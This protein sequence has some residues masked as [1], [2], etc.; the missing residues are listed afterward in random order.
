V[1]AKTLEYLEYDALRELVAGFAGS[2]LGK[3]ELRQLEPGIGRVALEATLATTAEALEYLSEATRSGGRRDNAVKLRFEGLPDPGV[4]AAKV[5]LEGAVLDASEIATFL[6]LLE[7]ATEIRSILQTHAARFPG[8]WGIAGQLADFHGVLRSL[9]GKILPDG[10][11]ADDASV[12]LTR[13]RRDMERQRKLITESLGRFLRAHRETG[14]LQEEFVTI[15]NDRFVIPV[16][17]GAKRKI[18]GVVHG[19]SGSGHTLFLEPLETIE[20]NN[21]LVRL[22]EEE[23]REIHRILR[24]MTALL[25]EHAA[26]VLAAVRILAELD[27]LF[28]K[29]RFAHDYDGV[30]PSFSP[31]AEPRLRLKAA[32]HPLLQFVLRRQKKPIVPVNLELDGARRT[33]LI[34][35]P[36]TGGKTVTLKTVG[37]LSLMAQSGLPVPAEEA[38]F[39]LCDEMLADIGD[40]QSIEQ[41]LSTF[42]AHVVRIGE[43]VEAV[44]PR[45]LVLLDELGRAT[46]PEEGGALGV[47]ILDEF[48][49]R[50]AFTLASTHLLA[51]KVYGASVE[52]VLNASMGFNETTLEPTYLLRIGTPGKSAGLEIATRIGLPPHLIK[53]A[54]RALSTHERDLARLLNQLEVRLT[55]AA[56]EAEA[57]RAQQ[58][59]LEVR[60]MALEGE[61]QKKDAARIREV[62]RRAAEASARFEAQAKETIERVLQGGGQ[63]KEAEHALR[64]VARTKREYREAVETLAQKPGAEAPK[65]LEVKEGARVRLRD[66]GQ[67]GRV[68]KILSGGIL[69]VELGLLKMHVASSEVTE[70]LPEAPPGVRL[71]QGVTFSARSSSDSLSREINVIG[72]TAEEATREVEKFLD[73]A[74]LADVVR[75]RIVHGHGQGIL[76]KAVSHLLG[77]HAAVEKYYPASPQEGG[78]GATIVEL[79]TG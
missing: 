32:R 8:L 77:E 17:P 44:T 68:I 38:E 11:I 57:L 4:A 48:R 75:V 79:K 1:N 78:T 62:E 14:V 58:K 56:A 19:A 25:R 46:D 10:S 70:V 22:A 66:V 24:E 43:M 64:Q 41:S 40:Q 37:L 30:I 27:V 26:A 54:R 34:S 12:A 2:D 7:R 61:A 73:T 18:P 60:E 6:T 51:L 47:A 23:L 55:E 42:S 33:L 65:P 9:S 3:A 52:G 69:E 72:K 21:D 59:D 71:P 39:P 76:R 28:A 50:G 16:I 20:L 63:R 13:I 5:R 36:N 15:R 49:R 45:S 53:R 67:P 74:M 29:A 31:E 35:G